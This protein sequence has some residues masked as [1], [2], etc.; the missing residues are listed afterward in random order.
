MIGHRKN[1]IE[2]WKEFLYPRRCP[3]CNEILYEEEKEDGY[4]RRCKTKIHYI[5]DAGCIK[6]GKKLKDA[7]QT[8]CNDCRRRN[9]VFVQNKAVYV[10]TG[11]M[12]LAMYR[13][14]YSNCRTYGKTFVEDVWK[15]HAIWLQSLSVDAVIPVPMYRKK[16]KRRG[17]N[18]AEV[19]AREIAQKLGCPLETKLVVRA[20]NTVPLKNL[21][22][23]QRKKNLENAFKIRK[24]GVKLNKI[25]LI[26]DIYTTG[27]TLDGVTTALLAAGVREVYCLTICAGQG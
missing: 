26:D 5:G 17:Y 10:Y 6:C 24:N 4:C 27:S 23:T 1:I 12:K 20:K 3:G 15:I 25:L 19:L 2:E 9:H 21:N 22:D 13:F 16:E 11:P 18:Q 7:T 8:I 14:K